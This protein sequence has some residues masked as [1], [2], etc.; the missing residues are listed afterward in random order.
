MTLPI[1]E[2]LPAMVSSFAG[3]RRRAGMMVEEEEERKEIEAVDNGNVGQ[4]NREERIIS[5][6]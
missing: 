5:I 6:T 2:S 3:V 1:P 4:E